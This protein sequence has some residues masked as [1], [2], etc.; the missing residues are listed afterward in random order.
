MPRFIVWT[1]VF[2]LHVCLGVEE[3]L[4]TTRTHARAV[5][6][7]SVWDGDGTCSVAYEYLSTKLVNLPWNTCPW[8]RQVRECCHF[9][10]LM[11]G[12]EMEVELQREKVVR[13]VPLCV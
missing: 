5:K 11:R 6:K 13:T 10:I 3:I 1:S 9:K 12:K 4:Y 2:L 8:N 7:H